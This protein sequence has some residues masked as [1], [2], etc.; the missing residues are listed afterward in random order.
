M[1]GVQEAV[2]RIKCYITVL[3][4]LMGPCIV[5]YF[6]SKTNLMHYISSLLNVVLHVSD[7][8]S[9]HHQESKIAHTASVICHSLS[10]NACYRARYGTP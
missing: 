3:L 8:L 5:I 9:V 4:T 1:R 10:L 2:S 6:Y 7:G